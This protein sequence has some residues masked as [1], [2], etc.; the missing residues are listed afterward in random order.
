M[1][2]H[3]SKNQ[4]ITLGLF[5]ALKL[6]FLIVLPLT[7]D[8]A[9][10]IS[11]GRDVA[12]GYYD[13]PPVVGWLIYLLGLISDN[14]YLYRVFAYLTSIFVAYLLY[15]LIAPV[16]GDEVAV[17]A[18]VIFLMSPLSLLSVILVNDVALLLFGILGFYCFS[19]TLERESYVG[20]VLSGVFFGLC[21]LS[22]YLSAPMFLGIFL[23]L[24]VNRRRVNWR[25]VIVA[26][27]IA[28]LFVAEN[29]I[30]NLQN[31][32]NNILFNLFARTD[33][34]GFNPAYVALFLATFALVVPPQGFFRL[35]RADRS[36]LAEM[37]RQA[38]YIAL[39]FFVIFL[40][41]SSF[42]RI[43]LHW[44][45]LLATFVYLLFSELPTER[46][47]ALFKYNAVLSMAIAITLIIILTQLDSLFGEHK[48]YREV[49]FYTETSTICEN[50]PKNETIYSLSYSK[51]SVLSYH[52]ASNQFHVFA[53]TSK[54]GRE[55]DKRVDFS[56]RANE[57]MW[58][59]ITERDDLEKVEAYFDSTRIHAIAMN[60]T[61][62]YYLV[63]ARRFKFADYKAAILAEISRRFYNPPPWLPAATCEFN[64]KY[65]L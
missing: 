18:S 47:R 57:N 19:R 61:V 26:T 59:L 42:K 40:L 31:C 13:H 49:L 41:L 29:I 5:L 39:C 20:A 14:Y 38:L 50:L 65:G 32:W 53:N 45:F 15:R 7:G 27:M 54:Y 9:Y 6:A 16:K 46:L 25:L 1:G 64:D 22:K 63:E 12:F 21:F 52:C 48:K 17:L 58:I 51:N 55:D 11:W 23:Y 33:G 8:E 62:D 35:V 56:T 44:L 24:I 43:G 4:R 28:S 37:I 30:F 3:L 36:Q 2:S 10:F 60:D 34:G